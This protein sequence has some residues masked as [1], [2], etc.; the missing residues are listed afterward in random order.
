MA[1]YGVYGGSGIPEALVGIDAVIVGDK[2][3]PAMTVGIW[4]GVQGAIDAQKAT[5]PKEMEFPTHGLQVMI[6]WMKKHGRAKPLNP[7]IDRK[8]ARHGLKFEDWNELHV[9]LFEG[10]AGAFQSG[11]RAR[12]LA[13]KSNLAFER[14]R[15]GI[16]RRFPTLARQIL[17]DDLDG[18]MIRVAHPVT[19][20]LC[21]PE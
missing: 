7:E 16:A 8:Y 1:A 14:F 4:A 11:A 10:L 5:Q 12:G 19:T 2:V 9:E 18:P 3:G 21:Y 20:A 17:G 15:Q 6:A 13:E